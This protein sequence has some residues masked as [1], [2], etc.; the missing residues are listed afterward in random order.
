MPTVI[1]I[2]G[3]GFRPAWM[4]PLADALAP[5]PCTLL[6]ATGLIREGMNQQT[7]PEEALVRHFDRAPSPA[8]LIAWSL[9]SIIAL[10]ALPFV[11]GKILHLHLLSPTLRFLRD[12]NYLCALPPSELARLWKGISHKPQSILPL[13]ARQAARPNSGWLPD[14]IPADWLEDDSEALL[15]G[16]QILAETDLRN[17]PLPP[18]PTSI[19]HGKDDSIIPVNASRP[20]AATFP[21]A[22][23]N[24]I[25]NLGH[26]TP[27]YHPQMQAGLIRSL[28]P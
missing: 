25:P 6:S 24:R 4:Q 5:W 13:F 27:L 16:L 26:L 19:L 22:S 14:P 15:E 21:N 12:E 7:S 23:L 20:I 1:L 11:H 2:S 8:L 9:G 10:K 18:I 3:W 28:L 17:T